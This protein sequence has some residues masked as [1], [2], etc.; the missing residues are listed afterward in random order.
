MRIGENNS[1]TVETGRDVGGEVCREKWNGFLAGELLRTGA[2]E[3][4]TAQETQRLR[5][6]RSSNE[7]VK[8]P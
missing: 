2:Q 4:A 5:A 6:M 1:A 8:A 3:L 7:K